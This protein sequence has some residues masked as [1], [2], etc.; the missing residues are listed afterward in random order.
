[1]KKS[2]Y[3]N[4]K[5]QTGMNQIIIADNR[6]G[7]CTVLHKTLVEMIKYI[8]MNIPGVERVYKINI[9]NLEEGLKITLDVFIQLGHSIPSLGVQIQS[10]IKQE[11]GNITALHIES[12]NLNIVGFKWKNK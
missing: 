3:L 11:L 10:G 1:M 7:N 5:G 2:I 9:V 12:V 8:C 4:F 6:L